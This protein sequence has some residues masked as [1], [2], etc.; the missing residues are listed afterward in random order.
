LRCPIRHLLNATYAPSYPNFYC[1]SV[2]RRRDPVNFKMTYFGDKAPKVSATVISLAAIAYVVFGLRVHTRLRNKGWG[3]DDWC[4][5]V[6]TVS[7]L[8]RDYTSSSEL[9]L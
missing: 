2:R 9:T 6:A 4:M 5:M 8:L 3:I 1:L 7:D